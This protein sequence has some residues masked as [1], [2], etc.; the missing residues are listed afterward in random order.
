MADSL[1]M[2][3]YLPCVGLVVLAGA[4]TFVVLPEERPQPPPGVDEGGPL[5]TVV[6]DAGHGG[7][8]DGAINN[9][10]REKDLTLDV[11]TRLE[12]DLRSLNF[13]T[14]MTRRD[15]QFISLEERARI[16]NEQAHGLFVSIHFNQ[17]SS[18]T[19]DGVETFFAESKIPPEPEWS[20]LG[21]FHVDEPPALDKGEALAGFI[22]TSLVAK[23]EAQN[24]GIKGRRLHVVRH[25]RCPAV[26]VEAGF[27]SNV[28]EAQ[29]LSNT[30]YR[31]RIAAAIAEGIANYQKSRPA[32]GAAPVA[33][34][35]ASAE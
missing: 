13:P 10:M 24:R 16:G 8:D 21:F 9:G 20:W 22:Q 27:I 2:R 28:F 1:A 33:T 23:I 31:D 4:A 30:D 15:D 6:I 26:L 5:P 19:V 3:A 34:P 7:K 12:R 29:L 35:R 18:P 32:P 14:V 11:A 17:A 25:V